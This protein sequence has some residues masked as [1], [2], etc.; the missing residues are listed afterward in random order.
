MIYTNRR[1]ER[2]ENSHYLRWNVKAAGN[3]LSAF[4]AVLPK[5]AE[6]HK[7]MGITYSQF[8]KTD[9]NFSYY[10][11]YDN[12]TMM[13]Y[14]VYGGI[15]KGYGNSVAMPLEEDYFSGGAFSLRG[16]HA[17]TLGPGSAVMDSIFSIPNQ[18]GDIKLEANMEFRFKIAGPFEG[19]LFL[20]IGN[21][22]SLNPN[23]TREGALFKFDSFYKQLAVNTGLGLRLNFG[24]IV[25]RVDWGMRAHDPLPNKGWINLSNWLKDG[26]STFCIG[27]GYPF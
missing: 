23:D 13:A 27:I 12:V 4:N 14:R 18:M 20:D 6:G 24:I 22:W 19:A 17:R 16:W 10:H 21:I 2:R 1:P 9:I 25:V 3:L 15:G 11:V 5:D 7:I 26:N 8:A